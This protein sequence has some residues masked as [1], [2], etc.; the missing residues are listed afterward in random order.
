MWMVKSAWKSIFFECQASFYLRFIDHL[1]LSLYSLYT[2][3]SIC[4]KV[5]F[6]S[7]CLRC[8]SLWSLWFLSIYLNFLRHKSTGYWVLLTSHVS[9]R[10]LCMFLRIMRRPKNVLVMIN[11]M[12]VFCVL[13]KWPQ[14]STLNI[15]S[16]SGF[17]S[18]LSWVQL[19]FSYKLI[20]DIQE[21]QSWYYLVFYL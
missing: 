4:S 9:I 6:P 10:W 11:W 21:F 1:S 5:L 3:T 12:F 16:Q 7:P 14:M 13:W 17:L 19:H 2:R 18:R 8:S 15:Y 20:L